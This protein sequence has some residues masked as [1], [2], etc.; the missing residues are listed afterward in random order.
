V[1]AVEA[2]AGNSASGANVAAEEAEKAAE[3]E[4]E[5][6]AEEEAEAAAIYYKC[7]KY[8]TTLVFCIH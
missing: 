1:A 6:A 8:D 4:A 5:K 7:V 3:E 2:G